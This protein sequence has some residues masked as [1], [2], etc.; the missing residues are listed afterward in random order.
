M[1]VR[2]INYKNTLTAIEMLMEYATAFD[3]PDEQHMIRYEDAVEK[4]TK[5]Y[6]IDLEGWRSYREFGYDKGLV[7]V[8]ISD[9]RLMLLLIYSYGIA[10]ME[11]SFFSYDNASGLVCN[12][13]Y[14]KGVRRINVNGG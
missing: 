4:C 11:G 10:D 13:I 5:E 7:V 8:H 12:L 9:M 3:Q 14:R 2:K 6:M 1:S